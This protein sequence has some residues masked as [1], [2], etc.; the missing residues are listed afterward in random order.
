MQRLHKAQLLARGWPWELLAKGS[1]LGIGSRLVR[2]PEVS[3]LTPSLRKGKGSSRS[4]GLG[5]HRLPPPASGRCREPRN[6]SFPTCLVPL[7]PPFLLSL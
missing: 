3:S 7:C 4:Q 2:G 1:P 5:W 6:L